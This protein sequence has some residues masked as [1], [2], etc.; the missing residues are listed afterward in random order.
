MKRIAFLTLFIV[1]SAFAQSSLDQMIDREIPTLMTTYKQL[2]A[3]P[4]LS[5]QE[6]NSSALVASRLRELG[7]EV[8]YPVGKYL[9]PG[10]T[11]YGVVAIMKNGAGPVVLV[12][13]DM[14]ALPVLEQT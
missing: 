2:H 14:D 13:S 3:A 7:Y 6:K 11:C 4:E 1:S 5:M 9:E 12:R 8:T 10:A